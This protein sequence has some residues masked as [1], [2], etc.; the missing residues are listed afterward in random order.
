MPTARQMSTTIKMEAQLIEVEAIRRAVH[1][2]EAYIDEAARPHQV[3]RVRLA[4]A[5]R[6]DKLVDK[7]GL[8]TSGSLAEKVLQE[9]AK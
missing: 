6:Y 7:Y 2:I 1:N 9:H 5:A 3:F 4:L 8:D